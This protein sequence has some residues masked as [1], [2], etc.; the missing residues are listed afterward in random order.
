MNL[1]F[2]F[3]RCPDFCR[4]YTVRARSCYLAV[5]GS[6]HTYLYDR[7]HTIVLIF[8]FPVLLC[9]VSLSTICYCSVFCSFFKTR[10]ENSNKEHLFCRGKNIWAR[11]VPDFTCTL[12]RERS[13]AIMLLLNIWN[14]GTWYQF[15]FTPECSLDVNIVFKGTVAW[16]WDGLKVIILDGSV[17][18]EEPLV[19]YKIL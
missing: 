7:S 18:R 9:T 10:L 19:V 16:D 11:K 8:Q 14:Q 13:N 4:K 2:I 12:I 15:F 1:Q 5:R 3:Y 6:L 17:L